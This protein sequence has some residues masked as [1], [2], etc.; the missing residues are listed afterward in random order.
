MANALSR[1]I[2]GI[3]NA[4]KGTFAPTLA[5]S[6]RAYEAGRRGHRQFQGWNPKIGQIDAEALKDRDRIVAR[7]RDLERN[8]PVIAGAVDRRTESVVGSKIRMLAMPDY[9]AMG[10]DWQWA[11]TWSRNVESQFRVYDRDSRRLCDAERTQTFGMLVETAYRHWWRDGEAL[12]YVE[13]RDRGSAYKTCLRLIDPDRLENPDGVADETVLPNG[14]QV[15]GGVEIDPNGVAVAYHIRVFHPDAVSPKASLP[16]TERVER[17]DRDGRPRVIHAFKR[18]RAQQ[19]RGIS[20]FVSI[21]RKARVLDKYDDAELELALLR[22]TRAPYVKMDVPTSEAREAL[23][24]AS[25]DAEQSDYL[26][27]WMDYREENPLLIDGIGFTQLF[28]GEEIGFASSEGPP[29]HYPDFRK[30]GLGAMASGLGLSQHQVSQI[31]DD[32]NYSN[33]RTLLNEIWRGLLDDRWQF[34]QL[35]CTPFAAAWLQEAVAIG[36]VKVPGG[37]A[38]FFRYRAE[39]TMFDWLGPGRG[40]IDPK[41]ES[42]ADDMNLAAG[43]SNL[44]MQAN[45]QGLDSRDVLIGRAKD[46][47][48][49]EELGLTDMLNPKDTPEQNDGDEPDDQGES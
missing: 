33:A 30:Q 47:A 48:M 32:I 13:N 24:P 42:D 14:N 12:A 34:S 41:K 39:L 45:E 10:R 26:D 49:I 23:A 2:S 3:G 7:A 27:D 29:P 5:G 31:W 11:S 22:A 18:N 44:S 20:R 25:S 15:I 1:A 46:K 37:P 16:E 28:A 21:M 8:N 36:K 19:R 17:E 6:H 38:N 35:F 43:R 40:R 9:E 4:F